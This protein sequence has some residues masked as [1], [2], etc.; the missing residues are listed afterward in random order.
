VTSI[1]LS[2]KIF[3]VILKYRKYHPC[4]ISSPQ[5]NDIK[6]FYLIHSSVLIGSS[7]SNFQECEEWSGWSFGFKEFCSIECSLCRLIE[8][9]EHLISRHWY[10]LANWRSFIPSS[11]EQWVSPCYAIEC[12]RSFYCTLFCVFMT[13]VSQCPISLHSGNFTKMF[14]PLTINLSTFG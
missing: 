14:F 4:Q 10:L 7:K 9:P 2:H 8:R 6:A 12:D 5:N 3:L 13:R 11:P 1:H